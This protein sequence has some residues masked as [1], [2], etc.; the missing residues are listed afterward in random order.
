MQRGAAQPA[1]IALDAVLT[2]A[3]RLTQDLA[4]EA[5][6][7]AAASDAA[8]QVHAHEVAALCAE[9]VRAR[10]EAARAV[11]EHEAALAARDAKQHDTAAA[12][13]E[14]RA[15][16]GEARARALAAAAETKARALVAKE[17][18]MTA[19]QRGADEPPAPP[20]AQAQPTA[21]EAAGGRVEGKE[22]VAAEA[23]TIAASLAAQE[24]ARPIQ[25]V[26]PAAV[27]PPRPAA[28][29]LSPPSAAAPSLPEDAPTERPAAISRAASASTSVADSDEGPSFSPAPPAHS[30]AVQQSYA[31]A[32]WGRSRVLQAAHLPPMTPASTAGSSRAARSSAS[33]ASGSRGTA[34]RRRRTLRASAIPS[35]P[36]AL[37]EK[38]PSTQ[39]QE[40]KQS[41]QQRKRAP[42]GRKL[43]QAHAVYGGAAVG[44]S[45]RSVSGRQQ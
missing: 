41:A 19:E 15:A 4:R 18:A 21:K 38:L 32:S 36:P 30:P 26:S 10:E 34:P 27:A 31:S 5:A 17:K 42:V 23:V 33:V 44:R 43:K 12:L 11:S 28:A 35:P 39:L 8:A 45:A 24:S 7:A 16:L 1:S 22:A 25:A 9:L 40:Q 13:L 29:A 2:P 6:A 37:G 14:T 20:Q 3:L